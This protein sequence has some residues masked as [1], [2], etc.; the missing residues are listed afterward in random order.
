MKSRTACAPRST[1]ATTLAPASGSGRPSPGT[2]S[3]ALFAAAFAVAAVSYGRVP[4][5]PRVTLILSGFFANTAVDFLVRRVRTTVASG[6][7]RSVG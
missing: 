7:S 5:P 4:E 6:G 3:V 2:V 1:T